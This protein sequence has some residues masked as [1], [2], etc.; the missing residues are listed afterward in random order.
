[1]QVLAGDRVLETEFGDDHGVHVLPPNL[2]EMKLSALPKAPMPGL[3]VLVAADRGQ[4][5]L[6]D[7]TYDIGLFTRYV[8][9]GRRGKNG[10]LKIV[11]RQ[12]ILPSGEQFD[13][14]APV[15]AAKK[16]KPTSKSAPAKS[17]AAKAAS[18]RRKS[19]RRRG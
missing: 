4:R 7:M 6:V 13:L 19:P 2:P 9:E 1:M 15:P 17:A 18:A 5:M 8:I 16:A 3:T 14:D 10:R 11:S 12:V